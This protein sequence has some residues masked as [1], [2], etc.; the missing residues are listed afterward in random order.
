[1]IRAV[2]DANVLVSAIL[3]PAGV[4][5]QILDELRRGRFALVVSVPILDEIARVLEYPRIARLHRWARARIREFVSE[6][7]YSAIVTS[8]ELRLRVVNEA[9][10]LVR[11]QHR[12]QGIPDSWEGVPDHPGPESRQ[13]WFA[14]R[15]GRE[16][17]G[18]PVSQ[19]PLHGGWLPQSRRQKDPV[20][21]NC[22]RLIIS[23]AAEA[24][25]LSSSDSRRGSMDRVRDSEPSTDRMRRADR[26]QEVDAVLGRLT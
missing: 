2:L 4:P 20:P 26:S 5:G 6:L 24:A 13:G 3:S 23:A 18:L 12:L 17:R 16:W 10:R 8:G 7:A 11:G 25:P 1:M 15:R 21:S 9:V 22:H 14:A 19:E